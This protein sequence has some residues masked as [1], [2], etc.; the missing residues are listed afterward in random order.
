M[1]NRIASVAERVFCLTP[2]NPRALPASDYAAVFKGLGITATATDSVID[3]VT[4]AL[5]WAK[6]TN[7]PIVCLGSLYMYGEVHGAL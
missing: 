6:A 1:A 4:Q 2:N 5:A 7:T 3:A